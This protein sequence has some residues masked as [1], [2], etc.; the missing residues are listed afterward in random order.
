MLRKLYKLASE[1]WARSCAPSTA[2]HR[3]GGLAVST[4]SDQGPPETNHHS[5]QATATL[6]GYTHLDASSLNGSSRL[7]DADSPIAVP[8]PPEQLVHS[9]ERIPSVVSNSHSSYSGSAAYRAGDYRWNRGSYSRP[10]RFIDIWSF[11]LKL[12]A[13]R[14][15][16]GKAWSYSGQVVTP[17]KQTERRQ[18]IA[19]WL[20]ETCLSLGPTF[21]KIGQ[22]FST[23]HS[24]APNGSPH[25]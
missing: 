5:E 1:F 23:R 17:E 13:K 4:C 18:E 15:L 8:R 11:V 24:R 12:L 22:L 19:V 14:W 10:Q 21:I 7:G 25:S 6:N 9:S 20:R 16:Y 3:S 2:F